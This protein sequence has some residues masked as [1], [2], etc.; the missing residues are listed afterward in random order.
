MR[1]VTTYL[2]VL[3]IIVSGI[4]GNDSARADYY[5]EAPYNWTIAS[6]GDDTC[7]LST[8]YEVQGNTTTLFILKGVDDE[9]KIALSNPNWTVVKGRSYDIRYRLNGNLYGGLSVAI[10]NGGFFTKINKNFEQDFAAAGSLYMTIDNQVIGHLSLDG[11]AL[12]LKHLN[13]CVFGLKQASVALQREKAK[14]SYIDAN[15][16]DDAKPVPLAPMVQAPTPRRQSWVSS[17]DYPSR[18]LQQE[19][20]GTV[21]YK[22]RVDINGVVTACEIVSSSGHV[23]LDAAT[24]ANVTKRAR[25]NPATAADGSPTEGVFEGFVNWKMPR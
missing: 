9:T 13:D 15:P 6:S 17:N 16:F 12:A 25:F 2:F 7:G 4:V 23:D 18:A 8:E 3:S 22:V 11:S 21:T 20:E 14:F 19:L 1:A 10:N 24:C 5:K